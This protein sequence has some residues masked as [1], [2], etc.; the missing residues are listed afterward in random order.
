MFRLVATLLVLLTGAMLRAQERPA[1]IELA[2]GQV[3]QGTLTALG[4]DALQVRIG[5]EV[6]TVPAEQVRAVRFLPAVVPPAPPAAPAGEAAPAVPAKG[7]ENG[8]SAPPLPAKAPTRVPPQEPAAAAA[9]E[10]AQQGP[11]RS[12]LRQRLD[13]IDEAYPWLVPDAPTQWI[14]CGLLL[15]A[16]LSFLVHASV[17]V[18]GTESPGFG[19]SMALALWYELTGFLQ[20]ALVPSVHVATFAMLIGNTALALFWLRS[21]FGV[22]RGSAVVAFVVQL[23]FVVL[24]YGVLELV[25]SLLASIEPVPA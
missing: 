12:R 24:G 13:A 4:L 7:G 21:L 18:I 1:T 11:P 9:D 14:S 20:M 5:Q 16:F 10:P 3:L 2:D 25:T 23:G 17:H 6:R 8:K 22:T 19:R 15:F